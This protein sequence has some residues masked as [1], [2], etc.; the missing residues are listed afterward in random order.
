MIG[1]VAGVV[2]AS[3]AGCVSPPGA[4]ALWANSSTRWLII[5]EDHG[6]D[7]EPATFRDIVCGASAS[8]RVVV[9]VEQLVSEQPAIDIFIRSNGGA[10]ART[11]FLKSIIWQNQF[12]DGRSSQAQFKLFEALRQLYSRHKISGVF[13]FQPN[14]RFPS[15]ADYERAMADKLKSLSTAGSLVV[16][17]VGNVHAMRIKVSFSQPP[18]MPMAGWLPNDQ[19]ITAAFKVN[20][21]T[22]WACTSMTECGPVK[23]EGA[24]EA[25]PAKTAFQPTAGL[26]Y[27]ATIYVG[28]A[29]KAS[30]PQVAL[31]S[32]T[33]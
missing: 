9:A 27:S 30:P 25:S 6:T 18:Y 33:P 16:A 24:E 26:P 23:I 14:A 1:L 20:G 21:G 19:T 28:S 3:A 17:L 29:A 12:K 5:G 13:A 32:S 8:R 2:A 10:S 31:M 11:A 15:A 22:Q 7:Q 4:D